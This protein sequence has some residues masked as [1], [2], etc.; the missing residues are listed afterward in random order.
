MIGNIA[1]AADKATALPG[2][3][4]TYTISYKNNGSAKPDHHQTIPSP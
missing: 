3:T 2:E 1:D 4:I